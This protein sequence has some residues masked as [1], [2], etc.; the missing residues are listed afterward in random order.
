[1]RQL[2]VFA[3]V[4]LTACSS[5]DTPTATTDSGTQ[6]DSS[7]TDSSNDGT[8]E[9]LSDAQIVGVAMALNSGEV[10][11]GKLAQMNATAASVKAFADMMVTD[12]S[13]ALTREQM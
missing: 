9:T 3:F 2:I 13:Q 6:S 5:D 11:Q 1:M 7:A 4:T 10:D 12:H 8:T